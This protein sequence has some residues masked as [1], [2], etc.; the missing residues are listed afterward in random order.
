MIDNYIPV[1]VPIF[2]GNEKKYLNECI[3]TG[4]ISSEGPFISKF[5]L[6][7][8]NHFDR[9][10]AIAVS[11]GTAAIDIAINALELNPGDE[12]IMPTHTIISCVSQIIKSGLKPV[13]VDSCKK[14][15][16]MDVNLI[17]KKITNKTKAIMAVHL[18]GLPADMDKIIQLTTRYNLFL[19]EDAAEMIGQKYNN[20]LCGSFGDI[21]I[22]S[23]YP[24]KHI[25][26][27]EGGMC[28]TN[29]DNLSERCK[30]LRNLC[31][32]KKRRFIH[33]ELGWNYRMTNLQAAIGL[34][35]LEKLEYHIFLKKKIGDLYQQKLKNIKNIQLPLEK[36]DYAENIY[37]V[38]G[39]VISK[40]FQFSNLNIIEEL[41]KKG[42]GA[43][44][45]FYSLHKQP[46]FSKMKLSFGGSFPVSENLSEKGFYI[47]SGLGLKLNQIDRVVKEMKLIF[48]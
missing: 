21:S 38:F 43:R 33:N 34:A 36:T 41:N 11:S 17:E 35:Q 45:F 18:Y 29:D 12:I 39:I 32:E 42:I 37:W 22:F 6:A 9:K 23:F 19:I 20:K 48:S 14:T 25:T 27:G 5:E 16:N 28:L 40:D 3:D 47:P 13:F 44:P 26:T 8:S 31:F 7:I 4:W 24:N 15:W 1:N 2:S 10:H 46:I 30:S